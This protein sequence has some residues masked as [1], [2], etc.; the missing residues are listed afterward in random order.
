ME[1][2]KC[3]YLTHCGASTTK[4]EELQASWVSIHLSHVCVLQLSG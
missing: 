1:E 3:H 2:L 4:R